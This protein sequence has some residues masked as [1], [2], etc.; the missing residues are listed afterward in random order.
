M[1]KHEHYIEDLVSFYA[2][3][4]IDLDSK[5]ELVMTVLNGLSKQYRGRRYRS[6]HI[7]NMYIRHFA[8]G[9]THRTD[10]EFDVSVS[11]C[12]HMNVPGMGSMTVPFLVDYIYD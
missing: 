7:E 11:I 10:R 4:T 1:I 2:D 12:P 9:E 3:S 8:F 5:M 6:N